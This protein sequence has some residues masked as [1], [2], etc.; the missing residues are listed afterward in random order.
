MKA[1]IIGIAVL[2]LIIGAG[3]FFYF[4]QPSKLPEQTPQ[5]QTKEEKVEVGDSLTIDSNLA[6]GSASGK[7]L[8]GYGSYVTGWGPS[9][10][11]ESTY[12]KIVLF[13]YANWCPTCIPIDKEF[14]DRNTEIPG[15]VSIFQVNYND[16]ETDS[17]EKVLAA[18]YGVTYQHTFVQIDKEGNEITKWNGGGLDKLISSIK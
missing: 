13:F 8:S 5:I 11:K 16:S 6:I 17:E 2:V 18:K 4:N 1:G 10:I 14:K 15:D 3:A 7:P 9:I 12:P